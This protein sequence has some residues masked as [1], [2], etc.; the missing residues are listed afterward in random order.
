MTWNGS[1]ISMSADE[2]AGR[3]AKVALDR[4][5]AASTAAVTGASTRATFLSFRL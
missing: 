4:F 1:G 3:I 2:L 5:T